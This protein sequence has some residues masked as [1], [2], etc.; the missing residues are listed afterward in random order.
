MKQKTLVSFFT[1][2]ATTS[3]NSSKNEKVN[4]TSSSTTKSNTQKPEPV[5]KTMWSS[6]S[7]YLAKH[8]AHERDAFI[9]FFD[10]GHRY[11]I[12]INPEDMTKYTS[13]TTWNHEHFPKFDADATI[14]KMMQGPNWKEGNK[15]WGMTREQIKDMWKQNGTSVA[16]AGTDMHYQI[17][18]FMNQEPTTTT[19]KNTHTDLL[20]V[21]RDAESQLK[22]GDGRNDSI[23][24]SHFLQYVKDHPDFI[25]YRTEWTVFDETIHV[26]GSIDMVYRNQDGSLSIYDW[27]RCGDI[28][29]E[30]KWKKF[31][32]N[33]I[34]AHLP[35]TNYWHYTLQLNTYKHILET[36][37][38]ETVRELVLVRLHPDSENYELIELPI[39]T[40]EVKQLFEQRKNEQ[41]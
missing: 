13:V 29:P 24:W 25:P 30:T 14:T 36:R 22:E 1:K 21:Y 17:E 16:Q 20:R 10:V 41:E 40:R 9:K 32:T 23:E 4:G 19:D 15:Y 11:E 33:P 38:G 27:K 8:N 26:A 3:T 31:A 35:D 6:H 7:E 18:C 28:T 2:S 37:Y 12:T 39:L 34:I 5:S